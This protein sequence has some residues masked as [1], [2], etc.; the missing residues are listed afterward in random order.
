MPPLKVIANSS[1]AHDA[2]AKGEDLAWELR[3][4]SSKGFKLWLFKEGIEKVEN[5][6]E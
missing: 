6:S 4:G 3:W 1:G 2:R 5:L